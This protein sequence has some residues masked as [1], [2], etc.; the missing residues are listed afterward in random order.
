MLR[1]SL[2]LSCNVSKDNEAAS[3]PQKEQLTTAFLMESSIA[4]MTQIW[5]DDLSDYIHIPYGNAPALAQRK[6]SEFQTGDISVS[7]ESSPYLC[8]ELSASLLGWAAFAVADA[9]VVKCVAS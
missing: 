5:K 3:I 9:A 2:K 1:S 6:P 8:L 4:L 7:S